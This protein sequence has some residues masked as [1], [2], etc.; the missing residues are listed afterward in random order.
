M[1]VKV[2]LADGEKPLH[3]SPAPPWGSSGQGGTRGFSAAVAIVR[4]RDDVVLKIAASQG[5]GKA[6][7]SGCAWNWSQQDV[8]SDWL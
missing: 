5:R 8:L 4:A 7:D 2:R 3:G 1:C 6:K